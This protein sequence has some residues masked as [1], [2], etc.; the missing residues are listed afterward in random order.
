MTLFEI[1]SLYQLAVT[2]DSMWDLLMLHP[3]YRRHGLKGHLKL[4]LLYFLVVSN[5]S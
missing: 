4:D 3:G 1:S 5:Y 2:P